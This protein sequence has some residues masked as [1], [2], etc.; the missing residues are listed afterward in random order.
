MK[1]EQLHYLSEAVKYKS[2]SVAAEEFYFP[3]LF[4]R[5]HY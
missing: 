5:Q 2:I 4:Q 3:A 1:L